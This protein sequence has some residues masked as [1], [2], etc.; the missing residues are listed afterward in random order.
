MKN[1]KICQNNNNVLKVEG[2]KNRF[3]VLKLYDFHLFDFI[4]T[5]LI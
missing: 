1:K 2:E 3:K 5:M 4:K